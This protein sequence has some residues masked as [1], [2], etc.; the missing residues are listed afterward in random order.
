MGRP[1]T[2]ECE[3]LT[4]KTCTSRN[5]RIAWV[6]KNPERA[7]RIQREWADRRRAITA[8]TNHGKL[9]AARREKRAQQEKAYCLRR[10]REDK[11][12]LTYAGRL[13]AFDAAIA[14]GAVELADW[15]ETDW[16]PNLPPGH[17]GR[18]G[19]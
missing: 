4:C 15:I 10:D 14:A 6:A 3:L 19:T 13:E 7:R 2:C 1:R 11:Q 16:R 5:A 8:V 18:L 12:L 9:R 17:A